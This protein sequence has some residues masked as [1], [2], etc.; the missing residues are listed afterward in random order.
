RTWRRL[1]SILVRRR[2]FA[3]AGALLLMI[4]CSFGL[5]KFKTETKAIRYFPEGTRV[6]RDYLFLEKNLS[7]IVPIETVIAFGPQAREE[8]TFLERLE[9]VRKVTDVIRGHSEISGALSLADFQEVSHRPDAS[10]SFAKKAGYYRRSSLVEQRVKEGDSARP[11]LAVC[12][13]SPDSLVK[14]EKSFA[15]PGDELW[16]I[17]AHAAI[18]SDADYS[19]LAG[20]LDALAAASLEGV[21]D[22]R[23]AVTGAIPL[24]LRTQ[25]AVLHSLV[26]SF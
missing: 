1:G 17:T 26:L 4:A 7:G 3:I 12:R 8:M 10:A 15:A 14:G 11:F 16:R 18:M 23:H 21:A 25:E 13:S 9:I 20:E 24:L 5:T 22:V 19:G 6:V 2:R